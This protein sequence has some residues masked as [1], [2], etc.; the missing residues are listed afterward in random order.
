MTVFDCSFAVST[1]AAPFSL[2]HLKLP[3]TLASRGRPKGQELTVVGLL[4]RR[5]RDGPQKFWPQRPS[6]RE[7][8]TI[9]CFSFFSV[10]YSFVV[11]IPFECIDTR[12]PTF[13]VTAVW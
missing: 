8:G 4:K 3:P 5:H 7:K 13:S 11:V 2:G 12:N 6:E 1:T 10:D 9:L